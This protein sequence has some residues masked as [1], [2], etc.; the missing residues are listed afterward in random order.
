[1]SG[2][3]K[4]VDVSII[5]CS[6][7][8]SSRLHDLLSQIVKQEAPPGLGWEIVVVDNNSTDSTAAMV[9]Q[10]I[11][12]HPR[13]NI[14][15]LFEPAQGLSHARNRGVAEAKGELLA[16]TDDDVRIE[17]GW[18]SAIAE[19]ISKREYL[20][21]GGR[22][23][24]SLPSDLP[25]WLVLKGPFA[26]TKG[27]VIVGHNNGDEVKE[28]KDRMNRPIG[29]NMFFRKEAFEKF[30]LFRTDLGKRGNEIYFGED[31]EFCSRLEA[32]GARLLYV[33]RAVVYHPLDPSRLHKRVFRHYYYRLGW[34]RGYRK[35]YLGQAVRN[36]GTPITLIRQLVKN[37]GM[38][39]IALASFRRE[40]LF[41]YELEILFLL[42]QMGVYFTPR[43][44]NAGNPPQY[45]STGKTPVSEILSKK[46]CGDA[47]R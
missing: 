20:G 13:H 46:V 26:L 23:I 11:Q 47:D 33:P 29:A 7:N 6:F 30:G 37:T 18:L 12:D 5:V 35:V 40:R 3:L 19:M 32:G 43:G 36:W 14:Q 25:K 10:F 39:L 22:I 38:A 34:T 15:Y 8:R 44:K 17:K 31:V 41:F 16:F 1:M 24:P 27:G 21:F 4:S 45:D 9:R 28:Y 42:G 2:D